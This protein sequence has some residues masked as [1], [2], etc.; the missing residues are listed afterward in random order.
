MGG[1]GATPPVVSATGG[2]GAQQPGASPGGS[3][4]GTSSGTT[5]GTIGVIG[6]AGGT[7]AGGFLGGTIPPTSGG[8]GGGAASSADAGT[9]TSSDAGVADASDGGVQDAQ[10]PDAHVPSG[11]GDAGCAQPSDPD[12]GMCPGYGCRTTM[13]QLRSDLKQE[14]ACTSQQ[15]LAVACDGRITNA[16]LQCTQESAFSLNIS[17]AVNS[18]LKR[19]PQLAMVGGA[20][21]DC[22][23]DEALCTLSRCFAACTVG[24]G[25]SCR[26][27]KHQYCSAPLEA[28]SG[29]PA[30]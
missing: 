23:V 22:Y 1:A 5:A 28:C 19:D 13:Q 10:V 2:A 24:D 14:G 3:T 26:T 16:A 21:L 30:P 25:S 7:I 20:C 12:S 29:L 27:C 4:A 11:S 18:C 8:T 15:A 6:G 9:S 17:R